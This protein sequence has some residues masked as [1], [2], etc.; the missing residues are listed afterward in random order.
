MSIRWKPTRQVRGCVVYDEGEI[1]KLNVKL[2][3]ERKANTQAKNP[4]AVLKRSLTVR[5]FGFFCL[6]QTW[7][8]TQRDDYALRPLLDATVTLATGRRGNGQWYLTPNGNKVA[9]ALASAAGRKKLKTLIF[10]QTIPLAN[11]AVDT[12][13]TDLGEV[14]HQLTQEEQDLY[15][16]SVDE[17]GSP[18]GLYIAVSDGRLTSDAACHHG[19]LLPTER[20]LH[21]S[22][23]K[24]ADGINV[25]VAT[26]TLAQGMNLPSEVVIISGDRR[27]DAE[28]NRME[29]LEAHEL[30]NAAGRAGRAGQAAN[31]FVLVVPS[32]VVHFNDQNS[33]IH[34][35]WSDL[36]AIFSQSDQCLAIEDPLAAIL[37]RIH[38]ATADPTPLTQ[39]FL[40]R[41]PPAE[42]FFIEDPDIFARDMLN[43]SFAAYRA[44]QQGSQAWLEPRIAA[45]LQAR[46]IDPT[47]PKTLTWVEFVASAAGVPVSS[48]E[49]IGHFLDAI[50]LTDGSLLDWYSALSK[51]IRNRPKL[52]SDLIKPQNLEG[53]LGTP[54]KKLATVEEQASFAAESIFPLLDRWIAGQTLVEIERAFGTPEK[55]IGRCDAARQFAIRVVPDLAYLF[56]LPALVVRARSEEGN[57]QAPSLALEMLANSVRQGVDSLEKLAIY[58]H[59]KRQLRRRAVH[60]EF[61]RINPYLP[62]AGSVEGFKDVRDRVRTATEIADLRT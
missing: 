45:A 46:R 22:L 39:Y 50:G 8:S 57:S 17:I 61:D 18:E 60:R 58:S 37:D 49:E 11:S 36:Q 47:L 24:R 7:Q 43:R 62:P 27:F 33:R 3:A 52:V 1:R 5:P 48:V 4:P 29:K 59:H 16:C 13:C 38:D 32:K 10:T 20:L 34:S 30:L 21:E 31:G 15:A 44:R 55:S 56:G 12:V 14:S 28:A 51:W 54:Y 9:A 26:S 53:L 40:Q 35:H 42:A 23:F 25:L 41:L 2:A 6:H 19:L